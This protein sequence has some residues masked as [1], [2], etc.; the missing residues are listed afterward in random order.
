[1][2]PESVAEQA[3]LRKI[4]GESVRHALEELAGQG[5]T[6]YVN[7]TRG[8]LD[9][10]PQPLQD[11]LQNAEF[12]YVARKDDEIIIGE[13]KSRNPRSLQASSLDRLAT[14]VARVPNARLEVHWLGDIAGQASTA[15]FA[16]ADTQY[17]QSQIE[18]ARLLIRLAHTSAAALIAWSAVE[19]ALI[20]HA[21]RLDVPLPEDARAARSPWQLLT[22]L[23]SLGYINE[24][25][26][27]RF[28]E[29]RSQRN[30]VA[31]FRAPGETPSREDIEYCLGIAERMLNE[32]YV[33]VDQ[34]VDW[35]ENRPG[36]P[37]TRLDETRENT[38]SLLE[39]NFPRVDAEDINEAVERLYP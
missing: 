39:R 35:Y 34:I 14:A 27:K 15:S 36:L 21:A 30:A 28:S 26:Q 12:D 18:E 20:H 11:Y 10:L 13:I 25:D 16:H 2:R 22:Y 1:V 7:V 19:G 5:W 24:T 33:S 29:L 31:H 4:A 37:L 6:V 9:W 23:D 32:Q 38:R 17:V 8:Q 3:F